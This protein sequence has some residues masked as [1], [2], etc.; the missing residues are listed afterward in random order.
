MF[1]KFFDCLNTSNF[2][3]GKQQRNVFKN[4]YYS[5][6]D[7]RLIVSPHAH[8][9]TVNKIYSASI[10]VYTYVIAILILYTLE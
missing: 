9:P 5:A 8:A 10:Q 1:D 2:T 6:E 3:I 4:P 7:F